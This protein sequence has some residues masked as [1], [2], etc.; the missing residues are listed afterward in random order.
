[1]KVAPEGA[2]LCAALRAFAGWVDA[3]PLD[4]ELRADDAVEAFCAQATRERWAV[5]EAAVLAVLPP[6]A[7]TGHA[8]LVRRG[9]NVLAT[10]AYDARCWAVAGSPASQV[11]QRWSDAG[12]D[13]DRF[14]NENAE[15]HERVRQGY[16]ALAKEQKGRWLVLDAAQSPE[17]LSEK[18]LAALQERQWL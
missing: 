5:L 2:D 17:A 8:V 3:P 16:L 18:L 7:G 9:V 1:M 11:A 13:L 10:A 14:E 15:F 6:E 4:A 12:R